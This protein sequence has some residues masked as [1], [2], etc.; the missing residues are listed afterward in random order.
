MLIF[1]KDRKKVIDCVSV[2][3]SRNFGGGR[4]GKFCIVGSGSFGTSIDGILANYPDEK[5]AMDELEK[6]FSAFEN[7]AKAYRL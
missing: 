4:D 2:Y 5:T 7:G 6:V 3:V 1:S